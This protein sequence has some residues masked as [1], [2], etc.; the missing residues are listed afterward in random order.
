MKTKK[1][2]KLARNSLKLLRVKNV[3]S[4]SKP[5][6][7]FLLL[8]VLIVI[9]AVTLASTAFMKSMLLGHEESRITGQSIQARYAADSGIDAA[10]LFVAYSRA[11]RLEAGGT[12]NN[13]N[14]FQAIPV[15][16][17]P[18]PANP[19]NYTLVA[20]NLNEDGKYSGVRFGLQ[21]ESARLN[22]NVLPTIDAALSAPAAL[23][24]ALSDSIMPTPS[25]SSTQSSTSGS[26]APATSSSSIG[27]DLLMALPGMDEYAADAILDFIDP[28]DEPREF[29]AESDY[30]TQLPN[31]YAPSNGPLNSIEQLLLVKGVTPYLLF[32]LDQNRNGILESSES[33]AAMMSGSMGAGAMGTGAMG[34]GSGGSTGS[35][36][37]Q[38]A[39]PPNLGW[40]MYLTL[41]SKE[42]NATEAGTARV[43]L[44]TQDMT[45]FRSDLAAV[46]GDDLATFVIAYRT[47]GSSNAG[48][49]AG[50]G[51]IGGAGG[52]PGNIPGGLQPGGAG[53]AGGGRG[54][55]VPGGGG[56]G[57]GGPGGGGPGG[58]GPGGG[59]PG[60]GGPGGGGPGGGGPGGGGPGGGGGRGGRSSFALLE[61]SNPVFSLVSMPLSFA[62]P[63]A[64]GRGGQA[65]GG[66]GGGGGG[67]G[68]QGT[69]GGGGGGRG[70]QGGG[71]RGGQG[72]QGGG[73]GRGGQG[74][75]FGGG[76]PGAGGNA[77]GNSAGGGG[78]GGNGAQPSET[79]QWSAS[80]FDSLGID[81]TQPG[82]FQVNGVL[83][84][85][86]A[87]F[88]A[89]VD[90]REVRFTSPL[91][92][93]PI[94]MALYLPMLMDKVTTVEAP[95]LPGRININE[96]PRE[97]LGGL[98]GMTDEIL[99]KLIESRSSQS[100]TENRKYE[101]WPMVEGILTLD[102]MKTIAP[103]IT[104]GGDVMR[105]QCVGYFEQSSGF[106]RTEA[107]IDGSGS[108]P[109][110]VLYR[111]LDHLGRGFSQSTLGQ[112]AMGN[113]VVSTP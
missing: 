88:T 38:Q 64:G 108:V 72:A 24:G 83:E 30:Y 40:A 93:S 113:A 22:L 60:G 3:G 65:G 41:Y 82:Q 26:G 11:A 39:N 17:T 57:G 74:G 71:G 68:G 35:G 112:R 53:G 18:D 54:G 28:D 58:G 55:G 107:V 16:Q 61:L 62:Q 27:R 37:D 66:Q 91:T 79:R 2:S 63:P 47:L 33:N 12:F 69:Q 86:D 87:S 48:G 32:G 46:V 94:Q 13:P 44:N 85:I 89:T 100:D 25:T 7:G 15:L 90:G 42:R 77:G 5:R 1:R 10:R 81:E 106:A 84:L 104:G 56:R 45:N 70:G 67:R 43:N 103:L 105:V 80:S 76:I 19:C 51:A 59:G 99:D 36:Q 101:T 97:I 73:G 98:P 102:Q 109:V 75:G 78:A 95:M 110:I 4:V 20:P 96:A 21:N 49:L 52:L 31:P 9:S 8:A 23:L 29:G 50:L 111:K 6:R 14:V 34:A 92:A